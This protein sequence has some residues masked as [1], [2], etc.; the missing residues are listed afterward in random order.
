MAH[1]TGIPVWANFTEDDN[2]LIFCELRS[3]REP[4]DHIAKKY[5]GGGH[6]LACGCTVRTWDETDMILSDLDIIAERI[7]SNE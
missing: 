7:Q 6:A 1:I 4:I 3:S 2:G 5:G